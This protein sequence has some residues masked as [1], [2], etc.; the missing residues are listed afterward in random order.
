[1]GN[2]VA[3]LL[4]SWLLAAGSAGAV[5]PTRVAPSAQQVEPLEVGARIPD[6]EVRGV[7]DR[8]VSLDSLTGGGVVALVFY[9]GGW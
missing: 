4:L 9:R 3:L 1:V 8:P 6:A 2:T 7:D 5:T